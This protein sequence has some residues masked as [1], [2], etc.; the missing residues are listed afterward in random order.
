[1]STEHDLN[2]LKP[3]LDATASAASRHRT[4]VVII[5]TTSVLVFGTLWNSI[6][7]GWFNARVGVLESAT[8]VLNSALERRKLITLS[9]LRKHLPT[10]SD[11][12]ANE[13]RTAIDHLIEEIGYRTNE[14][15]DQKITELDLLM[16]EE[17]KISG[18]LLDYKMKTIYGLNKFDYREIEISR[19]VALTT[20][21]EPIKSELQHVKGQ[22]AYLIRVPFF[23]IAFEVNDLGFLGGITFVILLI[24]FILSLWTEVNNLQFIVITAPQEHVQFCYHF[25]AM[26]QVLTIPPEYWKKKDVPRDKAVVGL[27][28][29][30]PW[31]YMSKILYFLPLLV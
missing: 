24:W 20:R 1:M 29:H 2:Y 21:I 25:L 30:K 9:N 27:L 12:N 31:E 8:V 16:D 7:F 11:Q 17:L 23:G 13:V 10:V 26:Q 22:S 19:L 3:Y 14:E 15:I 6:F 18:P 5:V 4:I 28:K